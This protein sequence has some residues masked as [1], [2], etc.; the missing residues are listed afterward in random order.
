MMVTIFIVALDVMI[1]A[2]AAPVISSEFEAFNELTWIVTAFL[3]TRY[4]DRLSIH[5]LGLLTH[6]SQLLKP[7]PCC[8]LVRFSA[9]V[10]QNTSS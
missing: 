2:P 6:L 8:L 7:H 4:V 1:V 3:S 10:H 5:S 9:Y